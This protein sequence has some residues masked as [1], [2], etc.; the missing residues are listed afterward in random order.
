MKAKPKAGWTISDIETA[1]NQ[2][3]MTCAAPSHG[4][5]YK[6]SSAHIPVIVTVPATRPVKL[7]YIKSFLKLAEAHI[8]ACQ[9]AEKTNDQP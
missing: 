5:H 2:L 4:D 6:V 7:P 3:G 1:C 9:Q 8:A